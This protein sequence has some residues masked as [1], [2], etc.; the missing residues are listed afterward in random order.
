MNIVY[1]EYITGRDAQALEACLMEDMKL[2]EEGKPT[3]FN[4]LAVQKR[5][6]KAIEL[7]VVS[8]DGDTNVLDKV[9]DLPKE[10]YNEVVDKVTEIAELDAGINE[11]KK[12]D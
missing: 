5:L 10:K 7:C 4:P 1:K 2:N 6:N 9:L 12:T 3:G 11:K 8:V